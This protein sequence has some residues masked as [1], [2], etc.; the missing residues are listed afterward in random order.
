MFHS[1]VSDSIMGLQTFLS[2]PQNY[3]RPVASLILTRGRTPE[4]RLP[5][6]PVI[7]MTYPIP[8]ARCPSH[9]MATGS[10]SKSLPY[11]TISLTPGHWGPGTKPAAPQNCSSE[12]QDNLNSTPP[13][14]FP[15]HRWE[16]YL[17]G[18]MASSSHIPQQCQ[19]CQEGRQPTTSPAFP[20]WGC[21]V[22][23]SGEGKENQAG[24][25]L[26]SSF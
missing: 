13:L 8:K 21:R 23:A 24:G 2:V 15:E 26:S 9:L 20:L 6:Q 10:P 1:I 22:E 17:G 14:L 19:R 12:T 11:S 5:C 25:H 16:S 18:K 7:A 4:A 3:Y